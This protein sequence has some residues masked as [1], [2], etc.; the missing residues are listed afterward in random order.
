MVNQVRFVLFDG[1]ISVNTRANIITALIVLA[2]FC[3]SVAL[4]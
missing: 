3:V 4:S 1:K 2:C